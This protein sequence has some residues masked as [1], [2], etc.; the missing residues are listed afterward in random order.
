MTQSNDEDN[1]NRPLT[2]LCLTGGGVSGGLCQL[3]ALSALQ[4]VF[5]SA[6]FDLIVGTS[7]GAAVAAAIA[8]E[9]PVV[10]LYRALLDPADNYFRLERSHVF[11]LDIAEWRRT[12]LSAVNAGRHGFATLLA[13]SPAPMPA[14][15]WEQMDR[16]FDA[17]PAGLLSLD[18]YEHFLAD[19]FLRRQVPNSFRSIHHNLLITAMDLDAG[20]MVLF[21]SPGL[22]HVP[23]SL[24]C[25]ASMALPVFYSPVRVGNRYYVDGSVLPTTEIDVAVARGAKLIVVLNP[26]VPVRESHLPGGIPTGHG[27]QT[28]LYDKGLMWVYNQTWRTTVQARLQQA[29]QKVNREGTAHVLVIEPPPQTTAL[30]LE[31]AA[32][33]QARRDITQSSFRAAREQLRAWSADQ[34]EL[35][36]SLGWKVKSVDDDAESVLDNVTD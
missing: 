13:R 5:D 19:F 9:L 30:F 20:Q 18:R 34:H 10:R 28:S 14:N 6:P 24:A 32:S 36:Q 23:V 11:S 1:S 27:V 26:N 17:L 35:L 29:A 8:G 33:W 2:A 25:A 12:I 16:F 22:D 31:N 15:L 4:V 7:S 3:G 21:G